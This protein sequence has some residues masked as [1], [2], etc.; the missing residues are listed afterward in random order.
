MQFTKSEINDVIT[1][2]II[3]TL[4]IMKDT[5]DEGE[6]LN[7]VDFEYLIQCRMRDLTHP[8]ILESVMNSGH[9]EE[10]V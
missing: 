3:K 1:S 5:L 4:K 6:D 8:E 10:F 7:T 2:T 9:S